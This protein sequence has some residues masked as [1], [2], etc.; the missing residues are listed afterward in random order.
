MPRAK[1]STSRGTITPS[2]A[3]EK[4][5]PPVVIPGWI[6]KRTLHAHVPNDRTRTL[7]ETMTAYGASQPQIAAT[8]QIDPS[9]LARHYRE[10]LTLGHM[11]SGMAV[12]R[13]LFRIATTPK[14]TAPVVSAAIWWTKSMM[15]WRE[16]RDMQD[17]IRVVNADLRNLTNA[18]LLEAIE[19]QGGSA[20]P[21]TAG[22]GTPEKKE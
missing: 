3:D 20:P 2:S 19:A 16:H 15:G 21:D 8:L 13:N 14:N 11:R 17:D 6:D 22:G 12:S 4:R 18:Q 10:Q 5:A 7:V 9:T 1:K